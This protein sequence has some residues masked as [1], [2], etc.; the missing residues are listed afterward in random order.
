MVA[1]RFMLLFES[2]VTLQPKI[3]PIQNKKHMVLHANGNKKEPKGSFLAEVL[4]NF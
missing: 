3:L 2:S 1:K 4:F